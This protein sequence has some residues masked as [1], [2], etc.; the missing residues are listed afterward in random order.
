MKIGILS[1]THGIWR[2]QIEP[3]FQGVERIFH[4]GDV[5]RLEI[6]ENLSA[7]APV[8]AV[9]GNVDEYAEAGH[10]P[11]EIEAEVEDVRFLVRHVG[12]NVEATPSDLKR[13]LQSR[14]IGVFLFGHSHKMYSEY[15]GPTLFFNPGAAGPR[16]FSLP[17]SVA[18]MEIR[19]GEL[20]WRFWE[21]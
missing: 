20:S 4:A 18:T 10:L 12:C 14:E 5:G 2:P 8:L 21:L 7:I 13:L 6:L 1:D 15:L 17:L 11:A 16:R 19:R 3:C 9:R